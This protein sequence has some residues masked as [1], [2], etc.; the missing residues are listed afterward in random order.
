MLTNCMTLTPFFAILASA[1]LGLVNSLSSLLG[2]LV[3]AFP[4]WR[5]L[6]AYDLN[7]DTIT[8]HLMISNV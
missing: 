4:K 5:K 2:F 7:F 1:T 3:W 6:T 8:P